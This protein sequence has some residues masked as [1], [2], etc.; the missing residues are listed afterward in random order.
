MLEARSGARKAARS[1]QPLLS[2]ECTS[3]MDFLF[4]LAL[5]AA[6]AAACFS[7][8]STAASAAVDSGTGPSAA[9]LAGASCYLAHVI[10]YACCRVF[11][12]ARLLSDSVRWDQIQ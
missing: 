11:K 9:F 12:L 2:M 4:A 5:A 7:F 3:M 10:V 8:I 1:T 6:A